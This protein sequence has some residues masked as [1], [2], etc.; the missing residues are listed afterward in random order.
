MTIISRGHT[1][2]YTKSIPNEESYYMTLRQVKARLAT[3][4]GGRAAEEEV[5]GA[6]RI[7]TGAGNDIEAG[8]Q[9]CAAEGHALRHEP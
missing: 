5:F 6:E 7:T 8:H 4:M 9:S 2:G 1:G 3:L